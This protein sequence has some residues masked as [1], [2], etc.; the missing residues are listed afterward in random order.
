MQRKQSETSARVTGSEQISVYFSQK[1]DQTGN[2]RMEQE[3]GLE[4]MAA[5]SCPTVSSSSLL[6]PTP[7][8][9]CP[10]PEV[11][12]GQARFPLL[13]KQVI[14]LPWI[15]PYKTGVNRTIPSSANTAFAELLNFLDC[16]HDP[17]SQ[18]LRVYIKGLLQLQTQHCAVD[19][20]S[21]GTHHR[22]L[23]S[24]TGSCLGDKL[25]SW[26]CHIP[27]VRRAC[28]QTTSN[29]SLGREV[30]FPSVQIQK[31]KAWNGGWPKLGKANKTKNASGAH[32]DLTLEERLSQLINSVSRSWHFINIWS[33]NVLDPTGKDT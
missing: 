14:L 27:A 6:T 29:I 24:T 2:L 28:D 20:I 10:L 8:T 1:A 5:I 15:D 32:H 18:N 16:H 11:G 25:Q 19:N 23:H 4:L 3:K 21:A 7:T 12:Q 22:T 13:L 9:P 33:W 17:R 30:Q 31:T 26:Q